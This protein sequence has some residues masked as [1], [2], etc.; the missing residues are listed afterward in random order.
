M[1]KRKKGL[2][3]LCVV[4]VILIGVKLYYAIGNITYKEEIEKMKEKGILDFQITSDIEHK[5]LEKEG[6]SIH[7]FVSGDKSKETILFLHPA[8]SD[9][10]CLDKQID[11]FSQNYYVITVDLL[12]HGLSQ[13]KKSKDKIDQSAEH[14]QEILQSEGKENA[15]IVGVSMGSLIAQYFALLYP[16]SVRS[17]TALGGYSIHK[18]NKEINQA[19]RKTI[20]SS[21]LKMIFSMDALRKYIASVSAVEKESQARV[22]EST[23]SF[24][25]KSFMVMSGMDNMIKERGEVKHDY[26]LLILVGDKDLD[27]AQ[28]A[29][30]QWHKDDADS[31]FATIEQAGHCANMDNA[32]QFNEI[33]L[34]FL[35]TS[36]NGLI[37]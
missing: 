32:A 15:H 22:Y 33:L 36:K 16:E 21:L 34:D 9:H 5:T 10:Q 2:I 12:G 25:R 3:S 11:F 30:E 14:I 20:F 19:Q 37:Q 26:P 13:V 8:Y 7:Y 24:T 31:Q 27:L 29:A 4:I 23:K 6:Y 17:L 1:K 35:T 28:R 18:V